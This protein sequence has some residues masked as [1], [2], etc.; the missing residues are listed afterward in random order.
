M[1][2]LLIESANKNMVIYKQYVPSTSTNYHGKLHTN[3]RHQLLRTYFYK[4]QWSG[5]SQY[6]KNGSCIAHLSAEDMLKSVVIEEKKF[7]YS[8]RVGADNPFGPK[9]WYQ[10]EGLITMG[11]CWSL[12]KISSISDF[13]HIFSWFNKYI[14]GGQGQ[15]T[16]GDKI[17]MSTET[18]CHICHLLQV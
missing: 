13:I 1:K 18:S 12:K 17:L 6:K 14:A 9:F 16:P 15:T 7:K 4:R 2:S 5:V 11:I 10:Q 3:Q 8:P